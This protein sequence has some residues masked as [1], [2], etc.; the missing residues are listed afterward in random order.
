MVDI[1]M[2]PLV[3]FS[4]FFKTPTYGEHLEKYILTR[5]PQHPADI[6]RL[7]LEWQRGQQKEWL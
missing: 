3:A 5:N 1:F 6:E 4:N 7:T 2:Q